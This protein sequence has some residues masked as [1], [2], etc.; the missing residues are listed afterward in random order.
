M[1]RR[2]PRSTLFPYTTLFRSLLVPQRAV[3]ELQG[4]YEVAV[5]DS[6]NKVGIRAVKVGDRVGDRKSTRLN[7]SHGYSSYAVFCLIIT[8][9]HRHCYATFVN[10]HTLC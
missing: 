3:T 1:I 4:S 6:E 8:A 9:L 5:V 2:P 10:A 7:P